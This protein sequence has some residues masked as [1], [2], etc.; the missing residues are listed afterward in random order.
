MR[1]RLLFLIK[2]YVFW[3]LIFI[4]QKILFLGYNYKESLNLRFS[5]WF[6]VIWNGLKIDLSAGAYILF[7]PTVLIISGI[8]TGT[9][10]LRVFLNIYTAVVLFIVLTLGCG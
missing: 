5:T 3:I 10:F 6:L 9:K 2:Y 7:I 1:A 4:S 8:L